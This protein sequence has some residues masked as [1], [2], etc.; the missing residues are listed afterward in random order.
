VS[1]EVRDRP[2]FRTWELAEVC[3]VTPVTLTI[4]AAAGKV[5]HIVTPGGHRRYRRQDLPWL[6]PLGSDPQLLRVAAAAEVLGVCVKT[7]RRRIRL[8]TLEIVRLP[9]GQPRIPL[10]AVLGSGDSVFRE[11]SGKR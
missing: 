9:S 7:V 2:V 10:A 5:P 1:G 6:P 3:Q 4:W 11:T 8:G